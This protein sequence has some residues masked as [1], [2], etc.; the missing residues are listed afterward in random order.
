MIDPIKMK[1][2]QELLDHL[3]SSQGSDL[4]DLVSQMKQ[5]ALNPVS[6]DDSMDGKPKGIQIESVKLIG[7]KPGMSGMDDNDPSTDAGSDDSSSMPVKDALDEASGLDSGS[8]GDH[9]EMSDDELEE[10]LKKLV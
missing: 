4:K 8:S 5:K 3:D 10:L 7:K 6:P 2:V 1:L 9:D